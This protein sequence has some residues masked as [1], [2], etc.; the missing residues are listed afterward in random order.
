MNYRQ[1]TDSQPP[2]DSKNGLSMVLNN[3][4]KNYKL[5]YQLIIINNKKKRRRI[6]TSINR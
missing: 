5:I 6:L 2:I 4:N 1:L 3:K